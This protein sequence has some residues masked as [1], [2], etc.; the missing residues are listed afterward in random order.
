MRVVRCVMLMRV[1]DNYLGEEG[2]AA[3]GRSLT[4]LQTLIYCGHCCACIEESSEIASFAHHLRLPKR[5]QLSQLKNRGFYSQQQ[6][7]IQPPESQYASALV[8]EV[9]SRKRYNQGR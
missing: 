9:S 3:V 8:E 6:K 4:A 1:A 2:G 5:G 7:H